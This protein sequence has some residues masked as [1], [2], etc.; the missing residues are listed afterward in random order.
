MSQKK[1]AKRPPMTAKITKTEIQTL[2]N[3]HFYAK[4]KTK[5]GKK[6]YPLKANNQKEKTGKE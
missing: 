6:C 3:Q 2:K 5:T 4:R 1:E